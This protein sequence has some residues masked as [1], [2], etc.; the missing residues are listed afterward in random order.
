ML[1][2]SG[3]C[4]ALDFFTYLIFGLSQ[5]LLAQASVPQAPA[6]REPAAASTPVRDKLRANDG[7]FPWFVIL[8][9]PPDIAALWQSIDRPDLVVIKESQ[10]ANKEARDGLSGADRAWRHAGWWNLSWFE[11]RSARSLPTLR[12]TLQSTSREPKPSGYQSD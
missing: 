3:R 4:C 9:S 12:L 2:N 6:D 5:L 10:L 1:C 11:V 7:S 8:N